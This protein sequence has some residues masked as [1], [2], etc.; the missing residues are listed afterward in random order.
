[1]LTATPREMEMVKVGLKQRI[2]RKN[3]V[4]PRNKKNWSRKKL[5]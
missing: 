5:L 3:N 1:L 2:G 4:T